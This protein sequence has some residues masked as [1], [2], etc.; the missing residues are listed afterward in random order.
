MA[1]TKEEHTIGHH[2]GAL[3]AL[4]LL[5]PGAG[6]EPAHDM[7]NRTL[8]ERFCTGLGEYLS[9]DGIVE[10]GFPLVIDDP[11]SHDQQDSGGRATRTKA[12]IRVVC[13]PSY[14]FCTIDRL[15]FLS[16]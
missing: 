14:A 3:L 8:S 5:L 9:G 11:V 16:G 2:A 10:V 1:F 7:N 4:A 6:L 15:D 12:T 13:Q